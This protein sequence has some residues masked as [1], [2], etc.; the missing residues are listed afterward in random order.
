[1]VQA[2][3]AGTKTQTRRIVKPQPRP[4]N[5]NHEEG[6]LREVCEFWTRTV[7]GDPKKI[8]CPYGEAGDVLWVKETFYQGDGVCYRADAAMPIA[9]KKIGCKWK[10]SIFMPRALSRITLQI[11]RVRAQ[12]LNE[13]TPYDAV[14]EGIQVEDTVN[15]GHLISNDHRIEVYRRLWESINGP[16]SWDKNPWVWAI[17]FK[18]I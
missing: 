10:P 16:G 6:A 2:L 5:V 8:V 13:I 17:T 7:V 18:K 3:L 11:T 14:A 4:D 1:M 15:P 12:R 9:A